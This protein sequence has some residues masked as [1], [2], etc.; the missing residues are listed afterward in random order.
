[1][2]GTGWMGG[3]R[4]GRYPNQN[5]GAGPP[6]YGQ[7]TVPPQYT[8]NTFQGGDGYYGQREGV[9]QQPENTYYPRGGENYGPPAGPPP[10]KIA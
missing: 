9:L 8:G 5:Y 2:Y 6:P 1:M 4:Y 10:S 7:S 3:N